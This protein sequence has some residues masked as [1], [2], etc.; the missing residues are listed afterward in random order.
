MFIIPHQPATAPAVTHARHSQP[1]ASAQWEAPCHI[2]RR[3]LQPPAPAWGGKGSAKDSLAQMLTALLQCLLIPE[4]RGHTSF[5]LA[6]AAPHTQ[7]VLPQWK[8]A[9]AHTGFIGFHTLANS[10]Q[11]CDLPLQASA[12]QPVLVSTPKQAGMRSV[13][14]QAQLQG[15][16][17]QP[18][19]SSLTP[20]ALPAKLPSHLG[21][22][23]TPQRKIQRASE[24]CALLR[25]TP[26]GRQC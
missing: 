21:A 10:Y 16:L 6:Q 20:Q 5:P 23:D 22:S 18:P 11:V 19:A 1:S 7:P 24:V 9:R 4:A 2:S 26:V 8:P 25:V 12:W 13:F 15:L 17:L 3:I 14:S